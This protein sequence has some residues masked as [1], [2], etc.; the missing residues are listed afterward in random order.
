M[1]ARAT[2]V[3]VVSLLLTSVP[4]G[5]EA[6]ASPPARGDEVSSSDRL[7]PPA[8]V[9]R[10]PALL[11][12]RAEDALSR[13]LRG[14]RISAGRYAL[15]RVL[16]LFDLREVRSRYGFVARP[17]PRSATLLMRDLVVRLDQLS[18]AE[19]TKAR[20]ILA[21]PTDGMHDPGGDGYATAEAP[22]FCATNTCVHYV[23]T[24][25]DAPPLEDEDT[26]LVPDY[27]E[28]TSG[29]LEDVWD[30]EVV[31][32]GYR[33]PKSDVTSDNNGGNGL[34]DVYLADIGADGGL[35]GY[36]T[37]D[38]PNLDP[39]YPYWDMS[40]YCVLDNDYDISQYGYPDPMDPLQVTAAHEFFHA[41][42]F[43]YDIG[44]DAWLMEGTATWV[45]EHVYDDINDNRQFLADSPLSKPTRPLDKNT[46]FQ[47]YGGWIFW[48]FLTE[49]LGGTSPDPRIV[50]ATWRRADGSPAGQ[51]MYSTQAVASAVGARRI[52]GTRWRFRWAF[53]DFAVWNARPSAFYDEGAA[54]AAATVARSVS[55][56]RAAPSVRS[57]AQLDHLANR[58]VVVR[59][60]SGL[61]ATARLRITVDGP[62]HG[63]GPE[64][65]VVVIRKSG[66]VAY[67]VVDLN[68]S[69]NGAIT[70]AFGTTVARVVV[71]M[72]NASTRYTNCYSGLTPFACDGGVPL[73][74][75][76]TYAFRAAV[77]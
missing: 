75:N 11:V 16:S 2:T 57:T 52:G 3:L 32:L 23:T 4:S 28:A 33:A 39:S 56:T 25:V 60:G 34:L 50:R 73:D 35:Y 17:D 14:G 63:T 15:E 64:A 30:A 44:E 20:R 18:P 43:A 53:A 51:D 42:Q 46:G 59:R 65:S 61:K 76:R 21:R 38:D 70:V 48:Q 68:S 36:C 67:R 66:A 71:I 24:T 22:P 29:V 1:R 55:L 10:L 41:I 45:E 72:T 5:G 69:G 7:G 26:S 9:K 19:R 77:I 62:N 8:G 12:P 58:F 13:A 31:G 74:Q 40:A 49:Y 37:T 27:V 6:I 47:V 54:Y